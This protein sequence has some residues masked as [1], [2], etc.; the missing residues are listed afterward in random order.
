MP[1]PELQPIPV[2]EMVEDVLKLVDCPAG[3]V[4][5]REIPAD[6]QPAVADAGQIRIV[7]E[8]LIRNAIEAMPNGGTLKISASFQRPYLDIHVADTGVGIPAEVLQRV[9][10]P[11]YSTKPRG[12]GLG[13]AMAKAII[14]KNNGRISATSEVGRGSTFVVRLSAH[15]SSPFRMQNSRTFRQQPKN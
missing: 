8:N 11:F 1:L 4:I 12:V 3:I 5:E 2:R 7:L 14:E 13:L 9:M 15:P 6:L 10:E